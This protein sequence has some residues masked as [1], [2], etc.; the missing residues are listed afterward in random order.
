MEE[1]PNREPEDLLGSITEDVYDGVGRVKNQRFL[2]EV[3]LDSE[4][5]RL[6]R[7]LKG[8]L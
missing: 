7:L 2:G 1:L 3:W 4:Q 8:T 6:V 5:V